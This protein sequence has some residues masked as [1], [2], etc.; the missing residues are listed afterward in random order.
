MELNE[1]KIAQEKGLYQ[2]SHKELEELRKQ[3]KVLIDQRF[4]RPGTLSLGALVLFAA[5]EDSALQLCI[6]YRPLNKLA[7]FN[8]YPLRRIDDIFERPS[9]AKYFTET[10]LRSGYH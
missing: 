3:L 6:D 2:L 1:D 10:G 5:W 8:G 7:V 4:M 9:A